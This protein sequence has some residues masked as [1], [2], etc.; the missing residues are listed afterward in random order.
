MRRLASIDLLKIFAAGMT[1]LFH[2]NMHLGVNFLGL[3]TFVSEGAIMMDLFFMLS[4][5]TLY[6]IYHDRDLSGKALLSFFGKRLLA[7]YPLYLLVMIAFQLIPNWHGGSLQTLVTLPV[8][9]GL[10]QSWFSGLFSYSHNGGTWFIS[11][12]AFQYLVFPPLLRL[13]LKANKRQRLAL[14]AGCYVLCAVIPIMVLMLALPNAYSNQ[15]L[16]LLQFFAGVLLAALLL[17]PSRR[18]HRVPPWA[19]AAFVGCGGLVAFITA[20]ETAAPLRGQYVTY[21]FGTFPLFLLLIGGCVMAETGGAGFFGGRVWKVVADHAYAL[22]LAQFFVW[23][24]VRAIQTRWPQLFAL[25]GNW[26]TLILAAVLC[27]VLTVL[28]QD[29]FNVPVQRAIRRRMA[30]QNKTERI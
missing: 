19:A 10:M 22:F 6:M 5:F 29:V 2:C 8:E 16:R 28:L 4:G 15:L 24:P 30:R 7:I 14:L 12:L 3:T 26:K 25:H 21:G 27:A 17:E 1:F 18:A 20:L 9:L 13:V 23:A 11:C